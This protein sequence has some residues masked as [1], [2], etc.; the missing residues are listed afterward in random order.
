MSNLPNTP[1]HL[2]HH[3]F[4]NLEG[5]RKLEAAHSFLGLWS[6]WR[7]RKDRWVGVGV[8]GSG[9]AGRSWVGWWSQSEGQAA[10]VTSVHLGIQGPPWQDESQDQAHGP[11]PWAE[12]DLGCMG[13]WQ[14]GLLRAQI[15]SLSL[16]KQRVCWIRGV[17]EGGS[18][19]HYPQE[20]RLL[21]HPF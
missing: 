11:S 12:P 9:R 5:H 16:E 21:K 1:T 13:A 4:P 14:Q 20:K 6:S 15:G 19:P 18:L 7:K 3:Q 2:Y 10:D 17:D 8:R